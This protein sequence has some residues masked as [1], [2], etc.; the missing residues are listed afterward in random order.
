M[1]PTPMLDA[2]TYPGDDAMTALAAMGFGACGY[3]LAP[4][5]SHKNTSWLGRRQGLTDGGFAL[6]PIY[7]GEQVIPP[8][9][10]NPSAAKGTIDGA[11]CV[12]LM[13]AEGFPSGSTVYLDLEDGSLPDALADYT[14]A[15]IDA[16]NIAGFTGGVYCSHV[17]AGHVMMLRPGVPIWAFHV[18][19]MGGTCAAPWRV[20]DPADLSGVAGAVACQYAQN[21]VVEVGGERLGVDLGV[22]TT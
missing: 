13:T 16:I 2:S 10:Q 14:G 15:W 20:D 7:V 21:V 9:S 22:V 19:Q 11:D 1:T 4:T 5:P 3:Y 6:L 18:H 8:G 12:R 17:I